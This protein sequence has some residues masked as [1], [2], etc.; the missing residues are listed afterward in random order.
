VSLSDRTLKLVSALLPAG[1][2][3]MSVAL[4]TTPAKANV[5]T[6]PEPREGAPD[7]GS[8]ANRLQCIRAAVST[9]VET[10]GVAGQS[11]DPD[12]RL[13]WWGNGNG[14]GWGNGGRAWA[15]G[16]GPR[17]HNG[18]FHNWRNGGRVWINF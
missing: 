15:N 8:V 11:S 3:G 10:G 12:I 14:R 16:P 13:A 17:W 4:A 5:K 6:E 1:V 9:V 7:A 18:G 2:L